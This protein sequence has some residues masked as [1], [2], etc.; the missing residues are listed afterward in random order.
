[1]DELYEALDQARRAL[2]Q[3]IFLRLVMLGE[4]AEDTRRRADRAELT[5]LSENPTDIEAILDGYGT[6]RLLSFDRDPATRAPTVEVAHEALIRE[7]GTL[8]GW[9]DAGRDDVRTQRRLIAAVDE[10]EAKGD[11]SYLAAGAR[12]EQFETWAQTTK[13]GLTTRERRFL[14]ESQREQAEHRA[15]DARIARRV[16]NFQRTAILLGGVVVLAVIAIILAARQAAEATAQVALAAE[17]LTPV[18]QTL[19]PVQLTLVAG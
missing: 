7:W 18:P 11:A 12:L 3:S 9:L 19:T 6:F 17:T 14:E 13:L 5:A 1:A 2:A 15:R 10:W 16:Q 8:R 4:G